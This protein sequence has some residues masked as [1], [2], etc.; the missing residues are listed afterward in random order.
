MYLEQLS[1]GRLNEQALRRQVVVALPV[2]VVEVGRRTC[3]V[4]YCYQYECC[5]D[6]DDDTD[7]TSLTPAIP[8]GG[9]GHRPAAASAAAVIQGGR[10]ARHRRPRHVVGQT[11]NAAVLRQDWAARQSDFDAFCEMDRERVS[12]ANMTDLHD[13]LAGC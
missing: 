8:H 2:V 12:A 1:C 9:A 11:W 3:H 7:A 6:D 5:H 10:P 4:A 13:L